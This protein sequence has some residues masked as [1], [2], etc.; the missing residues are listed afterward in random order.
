MKRTSFDNFGSHTYVY[1]QGIS[2]LNIISDY[3][4]ILARD[5]IKNGGCNASRACF[6]LLFMLPRL[7]PYPSIAGASHR[8]LPHSPQNGQPAAKV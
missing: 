7:S 1:I 6:L 4:S 3:V 8:R 2:R 5:R